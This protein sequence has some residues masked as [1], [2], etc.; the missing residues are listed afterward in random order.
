MR[1]RRKVKSEARSMQRAKRYYNP[2]DSDVLRYI[3]DQ[4]LRA[5]DR[6]AVAV[7]GG[8]DSVAL[9]R[10]LRELRPELGI[11][12]AVAHFN[13]GLRG[14]QSDADEAFVADLAKQHRLQFF[15][16]RGNVRDYAVSSKLG[17]EAAGRELRYRWFTQLAREQRFD[18]IATAHTLDD[19]AETVMLKFL[20]GA[21]TKGLAGIY[22][23]VTLPDTSREAAAGVEPGARAPGSVGDHAEPRSGDHLRIVRPLLT[24]T[25]QEVEVYLIALGQPWR[26]DES[27][28]DRR[29]QRNRLRHD[30]L[31]LV[32]RDFNPNI[33]QVLSDAAE[34]WRAEEEYWQE[35]VERELAAR[36]LIPSGSEEQIPHRLKP[37]RD[38]KKQ[39]CAT[40]HLKLRPFNN[41]DSGPK[42]RPAGT[43]S[44]C[45]DLQG[46]A[47]LPRALQRRLLKGFAE[48]EGLTLDFE[49]IEKLRR[50]ALGESATV[51]LPGAT[52]AQVRSGSLRLR[53]ALAETQSA[54]A[55]EYL[56][57]IPGEVLIAELGLTLR[58][59]VVAGEFARE[60][61]DGEL[62]QADL[63]GAPLTVRNWRPGDRFRPAH[64]GS[65]EK[66]KRLFADK[67]IPVEQRPSW[68]VVLCGSDIVWVQGFP[69]S[70]AHRWKGEGDAV[71]IEV[72]S[73]N[74][75]V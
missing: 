46:F 60:L 26:E 32:E 54:Q 68:P 63:L 48:R 64:S 8:A 69:V 16:G 52:A 36:M 1:L 21:G 35:Q 19:Q 33:R 18:A 40:A 55:Y 67:R 20:R 53:E 37:V 10:V 65:E 66:L 9:L 14:E 61:T 6:V 51:G 62:L 34:M 72:I 38:D 31:P 44:Y 47:E 29:F 25:R 7:S 30:L 70:Q 42:V 49:H 22:P 28:L 2:V 41:L 73:H 39:G 23:V 13:H 5:G 74:V 45:F 24:V 43:A 75:R 12:L 59:Q 15:A 11:V 27:N 58:A 71:K 57:P 4:A 17:I 56:L 3:R 50:C